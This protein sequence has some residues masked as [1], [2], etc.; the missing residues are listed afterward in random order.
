MEGRDKGEAV[1]GTGAR[2]GPESILVGNVLVGQGCAMGL[3]QFDT[4]RCEGSRQSRKHA[5]R[6]LA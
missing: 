4:N 1:H 3:A 2:P 5:F 6:I